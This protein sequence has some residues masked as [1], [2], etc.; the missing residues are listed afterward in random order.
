MPAKLLVKPAAG[1]PFEIEIGNTATIGRT[2]DNT[3]S[4]PTSPLV[5]RQHAILRCHN[6]WQYQLI[7]LGSTNGTYV[8]EQRVVMPRGIEA[9]EVIRIGGNEITLKEAEEHHAEETIAATMA[10][11]MQAPASA[12]ADVALLVCD[13]RGFSTAAEKADPGRLAQLLG[14]WF[15]EAGN[16]IHSTG[17]VIDKFIGDAVLAYWT[18]RDAP[19]ECDFALQSARKLLDLACAMT[20]PV[21]PNGLQIAVA[22]HYGRVTCGNIGVDATRDATVIGDTVNTVFRLEVLSKQ[23]SRTVICSHDFHARLPSPDGFD[24]LGEHELKGKRQPVRVL[25]LKGL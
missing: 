2:R 16:A 1:E 11:S 12:A 18:K 6:G 19:S 14:A 13:I 17:G 4:F 21:S 24:D 9:G 8:G 3:V 5:S 22:L 10:G 23:L 7:D 15:R 20:W 25:G